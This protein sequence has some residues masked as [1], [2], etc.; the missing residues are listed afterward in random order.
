MNSGGVGAHRQLTRA[1]MCQVLE[2]NTNAQ[3]ISFRSCLLSSI[4]EKFE[5]GCCGSRAVSNIFIPV[6][7]Q[8]SVFL[9]TRSPK[10]EL[11]TLKLKKKKQEECRNNRRRTRALLENAVTERRFRLTCQLPPDLPVP[12]ACLSSSPSPRSLFLL[13]RFRI[14]GHQAG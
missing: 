11:Q 3:I 8:G 13:P 9:Q 6:S 1:Q 14:Q 5:Q 7:L 2:P 12:E 10:N 4:Q